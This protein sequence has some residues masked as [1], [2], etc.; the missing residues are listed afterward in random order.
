MFHQ[1]SGTSLDGLR[2][3]N[4]RPIKVHIASAPSRGGPLKV[5]TFLLFV[6][7][8]SV[9]VVCIWIASGPCVS[10]AGAGSA[11]KRPEKA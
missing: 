2:I 4:L 3:A 5:Y 7:L 9:I 10:Y 11:T 8:P 1:N 6:A